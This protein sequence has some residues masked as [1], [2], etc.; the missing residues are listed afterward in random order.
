M[1]ETITIE[2]SDDLARQVRSLAT[3]VNR[4]LEDLA[5]EWIA[6]A[7]AEPTVEILSDDELLAWCDTC[8]DDPRQ[9]ELSTLLAHYREGRSDAT[10][11]DR[12]D[13]LLAEYRRGLV[14]K[15]RAWREAVARGLRAL[16]DD[17]ACTRRGHGR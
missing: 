4:P 11:R 17:A 10:A 9:T 5:V 12:L 13:A 15:A 6:R 7:V 14:L 16:A 1:S 3:A 8:L 2:L